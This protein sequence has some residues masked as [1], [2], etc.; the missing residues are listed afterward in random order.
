MQSKLL[1][2]ELKVPWFLNIACL[3]EVIVDFVNIGCL[4][5]EL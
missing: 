2:G 5:V 1:C 3:Y 4:I